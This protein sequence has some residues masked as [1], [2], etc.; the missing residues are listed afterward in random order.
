MPYC[1][2]NLPL[3]RCQQAAPTPSGAAHLKPLLSSAS[4]LYGFGAQTL[5]TAP[6]NES[7]LSSG[8]RENNVQR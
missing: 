7:N 8:I 6:H 4:A 1:C 3:G 2:S 5:L